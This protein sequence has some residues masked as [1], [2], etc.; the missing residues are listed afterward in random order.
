MKNKKVKVNTTIT[1]HMQLRTIITW[2]NIVKQPSVWARSA[3]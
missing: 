3:S 1:T 2:R